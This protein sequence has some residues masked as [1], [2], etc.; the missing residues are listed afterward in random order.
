MAV[1]LN[2]FMIFLILLP[3]TIA[4]LIF[5]FRKWLKNFAGEIGA[6]SIIANIAIIAAFNYAIKSNPAIDIIYTV[7]ESSRLGDANPPL[8][9]QLRIDSFSSWFLILMNVVI[10]FIFIYES[11]KQREKPEGRN[12]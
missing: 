9:V 6:A 5:G 4:I 2:I 12:V 10:L 8:G 1:L 11:T 3:F 7:F